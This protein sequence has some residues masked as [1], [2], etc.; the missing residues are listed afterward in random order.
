M[1]KY[2]KTFLRFLRGTRFL[3]FAA[4]ITISN[5][6]YAQETISLDD[7]RTKQLQEL[8][9][10]L[11]NPEEI[12]ESASAEFGKPILDQDTELL[13]D[14][15]KDANKYS[16]LVSKVTDKYNDYLRE[17][18]RYDFVTE[19]VKKAPVVSIL[20]ELDAEFKGIRNRAY[21]NLG[22]IALDEGKEMEALLFFNDSF[23]LSAFSCD[24][25]IESCTRYEAEQYMK[26]LLGVEGE[27]Y[28][29]WKK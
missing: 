1:N 21:L 28:V 22:I 3:M 10:L 18:S 9:V 4:A 8:G 23:R 27:S 5:P 7:E 25:G 15:A 26:T 6:L 13:V 11:P 14:I 17:N 12:R 2:S 19:E 16:N 24:K 20:L 29:H